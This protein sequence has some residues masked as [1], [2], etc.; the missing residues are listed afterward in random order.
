MNPPAFDALAPGFDL[1]AGTFGEQRFAPFLE[2]LS[3]RARSVLDAGCGTGILA[4][5]VAD[6][7]ARVVG[8]DLSRGMLALAARRRTEARKTNIRFVLG[9][10]GRIPFA[11]GSFDAVISSAALYN[12][13]LEVSLPELRRVV[14]PGGRILVADLVQ[15]HPWLDRRPAWALLR[16]LASAPGH[17]RRFGF[18]TMLR[19]LSFRASGPWIRHYVRRKLSP[20]EFCRA[21]QRH[22]PGCRIDV[23]RWDMFVS[24]DDPR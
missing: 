21:Y 18:R 12:T 13:R 2:G 5:H 11:D 19:V 10:I 3:G 15:R 1:W 14:R 20:A 7:V 9:D 8:M 6:H 22:L 24:W 23:R 17:A 4:V 16:A